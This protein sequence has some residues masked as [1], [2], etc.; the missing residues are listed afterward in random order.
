[1][2]MVAALGNFT[3]WR[4][5]QEAR[6]NHNPLATNSQ[7]DDD[8][9]NASPSPPVSPTETT[10]AITA[11]S[12]S[13][14]SSSSSS[15]SSTVAAAPGDDAEDTSSSASPASATTTTGART[16]TTTREIPLGSTEAATPATDELETFD[17]RAVTGR[18]D[19]VS[20][21]EL[22]EERELARRRTSACVL[23][24]VFI[25]FRLWIEAIMTGDFGLLM[26]CLVGTSW[27]AR[28][29]R[30][31]REREDELDRRI[32]AYMERSEDGT[33]TVNRRDLQMLSFQAQLALAIMESQRN[34]MEG[35][36]GH[37]DGQPNRAVGVSDDARSQWEE[38]SFKAEPPSAGAPKNKKG[39][40]SL[41]QQDEEA[42]IKRSDSDDSVGDIED[43]GPSCT[44][45]LG[46]YEE[47]E[48]LV[49]LPC[50]HVYHEE[51]VDS[52]TTN[53]V[54][55]PLCN[56]DLESVASDSASTA[57]TSTVTTA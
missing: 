11:S 23:L 8:N 31:N 37:P 47:G 22:E 49:K 44:I 15:S 36:F 14:T 27:T 17:V 39:Y 48:K 18:T 51:C 50:G 24:A 20:L 12:D 26:L 34:M 6:R 4:E 21:S 53:H 40:G 30:H 35:N 2:S 33:A 16:T 52:W 46:E 7:D 45:C 9:E 38:F 25:L 56:F 57:G 3:N 5:R 43:E 1:M 42:P 41:S 55:C 13:S 19:N 28:W 54:R 10:P 32:Q 29:I